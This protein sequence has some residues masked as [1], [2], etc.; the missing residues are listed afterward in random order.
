V[1]LALATAAPQA[2]AQWT[3]RG[4]GLVSVTQHRVDAGY[5]V[6]RSN[7]VVVGG[8]LAVG[9]G[10]RLAVRLRAQSGSLD[11]AGPGA[12][13]R[14]VAAVGAEVDVMVVPWLAVQTGI[15]RWTYSTLLARQRWT[16][17][18]V[19]AE[20][21][22]PFSETG[23]NGIVRA[24]LLPGVW[25]NGLSAPDLAFAAAAGIE[26]R[27]GRASLAVLYGV[28]RYRF[29]AGARPPRREQL[30][31]LTLQAGWSLKR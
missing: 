31:A 10:T 29:A 23:V 9:I 8:E 4:A 7:G 3:V 15:R 5:G 26:Y 25:V 2:A 28:E 21:R 30:A 13:D 20:A 16:T 24:A 19:G 6:E 27:R 12:I 22:L 1:A 14:D 11:A 17:L 18:S